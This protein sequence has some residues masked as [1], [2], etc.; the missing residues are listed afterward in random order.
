MRRLISLLCTPTRI[1]ILAL[2]LFL[3]WI[4][5]QSIGSLVADFVSGKMHSLTGYAKSD[6]MKIM[7]DYLFSLVTAA[8]IVIG[9]F[10]LGRHERPQRRAKLAAA[11][12]EVFN[13]TR[14][15]FD[16]PVATAEEFE[17]WK[18][19]VDTHAMWI[20]NKLRG[21]LHP[22]EINILFTGPGGPKLSFRG[23]FGFEQLDYQNY[24]YYLSRG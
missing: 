22:S 19:R 1:L 10:L 24:L 3:A 13:K 14:Q 18:V 6:V 11:L 15:L 12:N 8:I 16:A 20:Q 21:Q 9:V 2:W 5:I 4:F 7:S 23:H 17:A